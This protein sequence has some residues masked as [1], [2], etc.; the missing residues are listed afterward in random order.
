M[1]RMKITLLA[2]ALLSICFS[3]T[4][5]LKNS[6]EIPQI[7]LIAPNGARLAESEKQISQ[8]IEADI[9]NKFGTNKDYTLSEIEFFEVADNVVATISYQLE[10]GA[11]SNFIIKK[12]KGDEKSYKIACAGDTCCFIIGTE[13]SGEVHFNCS[14]SNC[15]L[16]YEK[17]ESE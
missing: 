5:D 14:C 2:F 9:E 11:S 7:R 15:T 1:K 12:G 10:N 13:V 8:W 16:S 3:C 4:E 6:N 17:L